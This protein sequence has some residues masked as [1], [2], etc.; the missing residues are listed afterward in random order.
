MLCLKNTICTETCSVSPY[1]TLRF[2]IRWRASVDRPDW[3]IVGSAAKLMHGY[4]WQRTTLIEN[5]LP[6]SHCTSRFYPIRL[7]KYLSLRHDRFKIAEHHLFVQRQSGT[8]GRCFVILNQSRGR[9]IPFG[10]AIGVPI[11]Y[12]KCLDR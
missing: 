11:L 9:T 10:Y 6:F 8:K 1:P 4:T 7:Q 5:K 12:L 3:F 2:I